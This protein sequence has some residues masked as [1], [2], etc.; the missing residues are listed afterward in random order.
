M[1]EFFET[2]FDFHYGI[3][4]ILGVTIFAGYMVWMSR[5]RKK[6]DKKLSLYEMFHGL[7]L[8]VYLVFLFGA[9]LLNRTPGEGQGIQLE[10]FWSYRVMFQKNSIE[11]GKQILYNILA[12]IPWG[13]LMP[14]CMDSEYRF[15][16][17][18]GMAVAVSVFIEATQYVFQCGL[19]ELDDMVHNGLGA[20]IGY[21]VYLAI[22]SRNRFDNG[23]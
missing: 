4:L 6:R 2:Y 16:K 17:V 21:G 19:C 12:F 14:Q 13:I 23:R 8:S 15:W 5:R 9:T 20:V 11:M 18:T 3:G 7:A 22:F 10:L 1:K